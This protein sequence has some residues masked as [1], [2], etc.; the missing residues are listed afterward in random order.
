MPKTTP[1]IRF[2]HAYRKLCDACAGTNQA[3]LIAVLPVNLE[4]LH[5][6]FID[7]DTDG[8]KYALPKKG[9]YLLL[10]FRSRR[11]IFPTLRR[12]FPTKRSYYE[13][14]IGTTFEV[15]ITDVL[16]HEPIKQ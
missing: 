3:Q 6:S 10:L 1:V 13:S 4:D 8:G 16:P 5:P 12:D 15:M 11:G 7:Y 14:M 9:K 2:S